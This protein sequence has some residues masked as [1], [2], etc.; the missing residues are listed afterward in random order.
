MKAGLNGVAH[1]H[2]D[3]LTPLSEMGV[4]Y[5]GQGKWRLPPGA[6]IKLLRPEDWVLTLADG[7]IYRVWSEDEL[8]D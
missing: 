1:D 3:L 4:N 6:Q 7:R 8:E 2:S 5:L